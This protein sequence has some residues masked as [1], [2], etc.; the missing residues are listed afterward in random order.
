[1][2]SRPCSAIDADVHVRFDRADRDAGLNARYGFDP[3]VVLPDL[4]DLLTGRQL[5]TEDAY[6]ISISP[7]FKVIG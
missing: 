1:M 2:W 7:S 6:L 5:I 4:S 3:L